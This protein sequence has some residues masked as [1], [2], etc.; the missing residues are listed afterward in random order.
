[1]AESKNKRVGRVVCKNRDTDEKVSIGGIFSPFPG[2]YSLG[3]AVAKEDGGGFDR[4]IALKTESG[5][6]LDISNCFLNM[7]VNETMTPYEPK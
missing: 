3:L 7:Y 4:V 6:K 5:E 1:M 2:A